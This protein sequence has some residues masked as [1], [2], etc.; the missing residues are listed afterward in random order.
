MI[1][2]LE[3]KCCK[4]SSSSFI[5]WVVG[6]EN[7]I[8][9]IKS[10][11]LKHFLKKN[12]L[13]KLEFGQNTSVANKEPSVDTS[14]LEQ[15][16]NQINLNRNTTSLGELLTKESSS[17]TFLRPTL[18]FISMRWW[19]SQISPWRP[20][21]RSSSTVKWECREAPPVCWPTS[22]CDI[23]CLPVKHQPRLNFFLF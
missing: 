16:Y 2:I 11:I 5:F 13:V 22:C 21:G 9:G 20:V 6:T 10:W 7:F 12:S 3:Q 17:S 1:F 4:V 18:L 14:R 15:N 23:K 8:S 19:T